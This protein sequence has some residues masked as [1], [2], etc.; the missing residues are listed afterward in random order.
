M[1]R[2]LRREDLPELI[3][4]CREHAEFERAILSPPN[5][6]EKAHAVSLA[7]LLLEDPGCRC[8]VVD[9][10]SGS[11]LAGFATVSA[12]L[13]TWEAGRYLHLDCLYLRPA[14][15]NLGW[16]RALMR[17]AA[18][19]ALEMGAVNLQWQT[20]VWNEDAARFYR[21]LGAAGQ[22]KLRFTLDRE[23]CANLHPD[24]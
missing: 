12:D 14:Y 11:R 6:D 22:Q 3:R 1:T 7:R 16:G 2:P 20:P 24:S 23:G 18:A 5:G 19:A 9:A 10:E 4:L 8:W 15:R 13:A 21:R 17:K